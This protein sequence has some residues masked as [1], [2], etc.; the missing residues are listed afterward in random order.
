MAKNIDKK[1]EEEEQLKQ[2]LLAK[3]REINN[4]LKL[5]EQ[6]ISELKQEKT[7]QKESLVLKR[8][9]SS[10]INMDAVLDLLE[11]QVQQYQ[12]NQEEK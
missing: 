4:K 3:K 10:G 11:Q 8:I 7:A 1:L 9:R 2:K 12:E 5:V 6:T